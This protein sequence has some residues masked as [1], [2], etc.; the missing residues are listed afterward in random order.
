M[1]AS[2]LCYF[3]VPCSPLKRINM[4]IH[5][6]PVSVHWSYFLALE[7]DLERLSR[8]VDFSGNN[9]TYSLEIARLFLSCSSEVDVVLKQLCE[10]YSPGCGASGINSYFPIIK[11]TTRDF[12]SFSIIVPRYGLTLTPWANWDD[13]MP[14]LWWQAHNKVKH[15]RH[16]HF[17]QATLKNCLNSVAG[18]FTSIL[19]LS[20]A[21][22]Y[23]EEFM[24]VPKLLNVG[25]NYIIGAYMGRF[26]QYNAYDF[27]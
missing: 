23:Q 19:Y 15:H 16:I 17:E 2:A 6:D 8:Y 26:G 24:Q 1:L 18:L 27:K 21:Q 20:K 11:S 22:A 4:G 13:N 12:L 3:R 7:D 9:D 10:I 5:R 14:P 25:D